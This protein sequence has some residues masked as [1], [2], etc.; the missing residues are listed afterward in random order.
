MKRENN[1]IT[2]IIIAANATVESSDTERR[3][4]RYEERNESRCK[5][6]WC[7]SVC[8][9][10]LSCSE[11]FRDYGFIE[12]FPQCWH[13]M[14]VEIQFDLF[15]LD[16]GELEV[17]WN[18][19]RR[20]K[21]DEE[22]EKGL[23]FFRQ[24]I[25][26]LRR[27]KN[28]EFPSEF[29]IDY[30]I[31]QNEW[32]LAWKFYD[33]HIEALKAVIHKVQEELGESEDSV[34]T[35]DDYLKGGAC[36]NLTEDTGSHYDVF[37]DEVD[38][39]DYIAPTC[40]NNDIMDF[41]DYDVVYSEKTNYQTLNFAIHPE[42]KDVCM[43][44]D[45]IVQICSNYR[46]QY[47]EFS[48]HGAA[49]FLDSIKRVIFIGGGDSML[50]HEALKYD[51]LELVVGLELDQYVTRQSFKY[52]KSQPHFD[53]ERVEWWFGDA[54]KSLLLLPKDYWQSF[55]LVLVDLSETAMSLTV[56]NELDVF[57]ALALLLKPE[58]VM[59]KNEL[60]MEHFSKVFD[61]TI[62]LYYDCPIICSQCM[63]MGSNTVDFLHDT[64]KDHGIETLLYETQTTNE[65]RY[66]FW[67]DYRKSDPHAQG[68]CGPLNMPEEAAI[69]EQSAGITEIVE[70]ENASLPLDEGIKDLLKAAITQEGFTLVTLPFYD[71]NFILITM[72]EGYVAARLWPEQKY[73][74]FDINLWGSFHKLK[75]LRKALTKAVGSTLV[76]SYRIVVG[77][78]Y[79]SST[80]KDD[81]KLIGPQIVQTRKCE[82]EEVKSSPA[83]VED[84]VKIALDETVNLV[85]NTGL[86]V[87]VLCGTTDHACSIADL[88]EKHANVDRVVKF[89]TCPDLEDDDAAKQN[90]KMFEC[91]NNFSS[92]L[93]QALKG[94]TQADLFVVDSVVSYPMLQILNS[95]LE[96]SRGRVSWIKEHN[97]FV[98]ISV[99]PI[100][101]P[102]RS[103]F[104]DRC[105]FFLCTSLEASTYLTF[106]TNNHSTF[107]L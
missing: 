3:V 68:K 55:D 14:D 52:F 8:R 80:W 87:A 51:D 98:A 22:K 76:S 54:T 48:M 104:L 28:L 75:S 85:H 53:D 62:Q 16:N 31:P 79:G 27:I 103:N 32:D 74:G 71:Q 24:Q 43:D 13:Y 94:N 33:A 95:V 21:D 2:A 61:N 67:H 26:R 39:L 63:V 20:F 34:C 17:K 102:W 56:T 70:A 72:K 37:N 106:D 23:V 38:D 57:D 96:D 82:E 11:I 12:N 25:R 97:V 36:T 10:L 35:M 49:K 105:K 107:P 19:R 77:G 46:P 29:A 86:S 89:W 5:S 1:S 4:R 66:D 81:Q 65:N 60:Y 90:S 50:L 45:D 92:Q 58:G 93:N 69:Q 15:K 9:S 88:L 64:P 99:K 47:H 84:I 30:D 101:E 40:D 7:S 73:C 6:A 100:E 41:N 44:L 83:P 42:D 78:M 59:V 91:E 18:R